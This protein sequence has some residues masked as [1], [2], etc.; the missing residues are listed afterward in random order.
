MTPS[1]PKRRWFSFSLRTMFVV[2]T[3]FAIPLGWLAWEASVVRRRAIC[4]DE[5][6]TG[7]G[8]Y[9]TSKGA[10]SRLPWIRQMMGDKFIE[11]IYLK[12]APTKA[13][14]HDRLTKVYP[15]AAIQIWPYF[16]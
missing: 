2:V 11:R 10:N 3:V 16:Y 1:V 7:G 14:W 15:E 8:Y 13:M 9:L 5:V 12:D 6:T 4:L